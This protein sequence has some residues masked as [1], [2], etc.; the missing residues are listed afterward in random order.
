MTDKTF[1][2]RF[3]LQVK[4]TTPLFFILLKDIRGRYAVVYRNKKGNFVAK[5]NYIFYT[6]SNN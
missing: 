2:K 5:K 1:K 4:D 6:F 3:K